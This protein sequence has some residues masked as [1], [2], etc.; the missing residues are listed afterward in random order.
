MLIFDA[1]RLVGPITTGSVRSETAAGL[2]A[3]LDHLGIA[4]C[5]AVSFYEVQLEAEGRDWRTRV[6]DL[7]SEPGLVPT[8]VIIPSV[9][10]AS[11]PRTPED[12][13]ATNPV[14]VRAMPGKHQ[15]NLTGP[16]AQRWW[17]VLAEAGIPVSISATEA[18]IGQVAAL[19]TAHPDLTVFCLE[20]G[21]RDLRRVAELLAER[22]NAYVET[23]TLIAPRSLEWLAESVGSER[24]VFGT[25]APMKDD[26]GPRF[27]L[28]HLDLPEDQIAGIAGENFATM[29]GRDLA[30]LVGAGA[31][32]ADRPERIGVREHPAAPLPDDGGPSTTPVIDAHAHLSTWGDF[33]VP[34]YSGAWLVEQMDRIGVDAA[35]VSSMH[36]V[37]NDAVLG[38]QEAIEEAHAHPGRLGVYLVVDPHDP[39]PLPRLRDQLDD[40]LVWGLKLH[41][42]THNVAITDRRYRGALEL[43]AE[44]G[45]PVLTHT[46]HLAATCSAAECDAAT[47]AVPGLQLLMGHSGLN[48][49]GL[50]T[51]V[52]V[53][54]DNPQC[55][56][57]ICGSLN[58]AA[59]VEYMVAQ[60]GADRVFYGTDA[61]FFDPRW[62]LGK[63]R[64]ARLTSDD[65]NKILGGNM[66]ALLGERWHASQAYAN[67]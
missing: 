47:R 49:A 6:G 45:A 41:P 7:H 28:D 57:E 37:G 67:N 59:S 11:W 46:S 56:L 55:H 21:Y 22:P 13:V 33:W 16:I 20:P 3:E 14:M 44:V 51:F 48:P 42:S 15:W 58:T 63:M 60:V 5:A 2:R 35:A 36:G 8:P 24:L 65:R 52:D 26:A 32:Q 29:V 50:P 54:R 62:G 27:L 34:E 39:D 31:E 61:L 66:V 64:Y 38:N 10:T 17:P 1:H 18:G 43:A 4:G 40:P 19:A 12:L 53:A 9:G 30:E 25:G 23:G